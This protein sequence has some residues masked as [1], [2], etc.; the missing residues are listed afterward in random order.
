MS[1]AHRERVVAALNHE[2]TDRVPIDFGGGPATGIHPQ[3]YAALHTYL[4]FE[5]ESDVES[6]RGGEVLI[7]S[8][9]VLRRF[10]ADIRGVNLPERR[11]PLG[12]DSYLDE[13]GVV[14][15]RAHSAAPY[16]NIRGP[17][18]HIEEPT[19]SALRRMRW[20]STDG[21]AKL[22]GLRE[23]LEGLAIGSDYAIALTLSNGPLALAQRVRGFAEFLEDLLLNKP[24]AEALLDRIT[25]VIC[26]LAVAA[27]RE[28]GD[29][30]DCVSFLD[31]LGTQTQ[32]LMS[33]TL[34]RAM[35]KPH[36]ARYVETLHAHSKAAVV[37]HSDGAIR[38][39]LGDLIE[40]GVQVIN[41]VQVS[42]AGMDPAHLKR[43]FGAH[44]CFWGGVDTQQVLPRGTAED[45]GDE[46]R[47][48]LA[49]LGQGGGYVLASVH[50]IM[51][52]VPPQ[53]IVAMFDTARSQTGAPIQG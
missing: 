11:I 51:A 8:E 25:D 36:H 4:G 1:V 16:M 22:A 43:E 28:L 21:S 18:Q 20:P 19:L 29:L 14:W 3:A 40:C 50:H 5:P 2:Q 49:D 53:N 38:D 47:R 26:E 7:P 39:L 30:I 23:R 41:P 34:Y 17:L 13:W 37:M 27:L 15:A 52:E 35:I 48:R 45:V 33:P 9:R 42:A 46:V 10:D 24:F 12:E 32:P 31:D 44:L 6:L